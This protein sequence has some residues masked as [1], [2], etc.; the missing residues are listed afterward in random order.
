MAAK[1]AEE[2][3]E[4]S[5]LRNEGKVDHSYDGEDERHGGAR[6]ATRRSWPDIGSEVRVQFSKKMR[7]KGTVS[8]VN[9]DGT[10]D[11]VYD[12]GGIME[13][14]EEEASVGNDRI[15]K[16]LEFEVLGS[17][18][19]A[20]DARTLKGEA[21][22][23]FKI[24]DF[25]A[26]YARYA[27][28]LSA[29][30]GGDHVNPEVGSTALVWN[31]DGERVKV[32]I[33]STVSSDGNS[34]DIMYVQS[35]RPKVDEGK[36]GAAS[37]ENEEDEEEDDVPRARLSMVSP[38]AFEGDNAQLQCSLHLN[39]ARCAM[40]L[41]NMRLRSDTAC[42]LGVANFS[43]SKRSAMEEKTRALWKT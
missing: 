29:L 8:Y 38:M 24:K 39:S 22:A 16:L 7:R 32:G 3:E 1:Y 34:A 4:G 43:K 5:Y 12:S 9:E 19:V 30:K 26:A 35:R 27:S 14:A 33:I 31:D 25:V 18:E 41:Q 36:V 20:E 40:K 21:A 13:E 42:A 11:V 28:A 10:V 17:K 23:L 6:T 15:E 2:E 37:A